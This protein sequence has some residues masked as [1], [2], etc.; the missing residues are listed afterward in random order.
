MYSAKPNH[1]TSSSPTEPIQL[2]PEQCEMAIFTMTVDTDARAMDSRRAGARLLQDGQPQHYY[3]RI[4]QAR[5]RKAHR[6]GKVYNWETAKYG[7]IWYDEDVH[8]LRSVETEFPAIVFNDEL[9]FENTLSCEPTVSSLNNNEIDFRI[10]F[11]ES[12]D[13]DYTPMASYFDDLDF[14]KDFEKEFPAIIYND[15]LTSKSDSSTE[16]VEISHHIDELNLKTKTSLSECDEE[17][18]DVLYLNDQFHFNVIYPYDLESDKDNDDNE[19]DIIQS[20]RGNNIMMNLFNVCTDFVKIANMALPP[21]DQRHQYLRFEG[22]EYTDDDITDFEERLGMI[23]GKK[24]HRV[25][26]FDFGGLTELMDEGLSARMLME[27]R[28]A[29]RQGVFTSRAWRRLF[30]IRGPL[31]HELILGFFSTFRFEEAV[32]DLDTTEALQFQLGGVRR[33]MSWREFIL[34]MGLHT[35]EDIESV[36]FGAYWAKSARQILD[37]GDLSAY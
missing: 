23:Y 31:V 17:E 4:Y 37:K 2:M 21:V 7:K 11:D 12:D 15:A 10:S 36:G 30:K 28:D 33:R 9:S 24:I 26:V 34:G 16:P 25:Q 22:L 18:Q 6:R 8:D 13:E 27:H 5:R 29:Q 35:A 19:I 32:L 14:L 3:G 20:S 1:T